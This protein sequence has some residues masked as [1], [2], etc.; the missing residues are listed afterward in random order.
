MVYPSG[1]TAPLRTH[2]RHLELADRTDPD[3]APDYFVINYKPVET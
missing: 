1:A 2:D 3:D